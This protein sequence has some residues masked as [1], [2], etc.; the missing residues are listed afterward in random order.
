MT[1][2]RVRPAVTV[3]EVLVVVATLAVVVG[4]TA[5]AVQK[6]R[7]AAARAGCGNHLRQLVLAVHAHAADGRLPAGCGYPPTAVSGRT[8]HL[9]GQSWHTAVLAEAGEGVLH[10]AAQ[11]AFAR[12]PA[13]ADVRLHARPGT[14]APDLFRC[15]TEPAR[16]AADSRFGVTTFLGVA[17]TRIRREDG[18]FHDFIRVRLAEVTDG[19]S[20]TLLLGERPAGPAGAVGEWYGL[21][22]SARCGLAQVLPAGVVAQPSRS[23][24]CDP[25]TKSLAPGTPDSDCSLG[26]FWSRHP[27]GANFAFADGSVRFIPYAAADLLPALSTRAGGETVALD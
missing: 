2:T 14:A 19:L 3:V 18:L 15:P 7:G 23:V 1:T 16:R 9:A 11:A 8:W 13:G 22:G 27:G 12:D 6:A 26:H 24:G 20:A 5:A 4:L 10:Q 25:A 17:G 21:W